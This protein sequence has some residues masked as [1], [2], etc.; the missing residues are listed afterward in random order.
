MQ[1]I[2]GGLALLLLATAGATF[3]YYVLEP[4]ICWLVVGI[5]LL[6]GIGRGK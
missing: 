6:C 3:F 5:G 4:V 1:I 2:G